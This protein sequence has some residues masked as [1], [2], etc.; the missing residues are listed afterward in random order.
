MERIVQTENL[1]EAFLRAARG[2]Q[3]KV[4]VMA[5]RDDLHNQM[6]AIQ[7]DLL[8]GR[9]A[10]GPYHYFTIYD[11][12]RRIICAAPFRDRVVFHAMM[13]ICHPVF[14]NHQ[15]CDSYAS[16]LG[17]GTYK[18][19][20]RAG[21]M[22]RRHR[23]FAKLDMVKYFDSIDHEVMMSQL[24]RLFKDGMLLRYFDDLIRGYST[25]PGRGLPIGNLTSQYFANHYLSPADHLLLERM[26]AK[27]MVR[28]MDDVLIFDNDT[29]R[30]KD[31]VACYSDHVRHSLRLDLHAPIINRT[32]CGVPFLG[33]VVKRDCLRLNGRSRRRF[34]R[35]MAQWSVLVQQERVS[36]EQYAEHAT[37]LMAFARKA[38][39]R[40]LMRKLSQTPGMFPSGLQ[41]REPWWQ[42]EQQR[43]ELPSVQPQQQH[44]V[45]HEQ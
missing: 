35:K 6:C 4:A 32:D 40:Q 45:E 34:V 19:L 23:W 9:Y 31:V 20:E 7:R 36:I 2:K 33:Y 28:Y 13:R 8:A 39:V 21:Q 24:C 18:A 38:D 41:P 15:V 43:Q 37:C 16:R 11:P 17:K 30:L 25:L 44:A 5:F 27:G 29:N 3:C 22:A 26:G 42:L 14:D 10:F 12:K 1:H